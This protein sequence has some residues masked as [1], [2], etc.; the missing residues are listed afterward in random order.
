MKDLYYGGL[1]L[2]KDLKF[3]AYVEELRHH[4]D[5]LIMDLPEEVLV[6]D[7]TYSRDGSFKME[8]AG[9]VHFG[10]EYYYVEFHY[11]GMI[12]MVDV[13]PDYPFENTEGSGVFRFVAYDRADRAHK[14]QRIYPTPYD[15]LLSIDQWEKNIKDTKQEVRV[16][17]AG[18][19][20]INPYITDF[21]VN[22]IERVVQVKGGFKERDVWTCGNPVILKTETWNNHHKVVDV[23]RT[24][25]NDAYGCPYK[26][27]VDLITRKI[28][29]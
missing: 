3:C 4:E 2:E 8:K 22:I 21:D 11:H 29:G 1:A 5:V 17:S 25:K 23:I 12:F 16:I 27:S 10:Y 13:S 6:H 9:T 20:R 15:G 26:F 18:Y 14:K 24:D 19:Q 28:C 7:M